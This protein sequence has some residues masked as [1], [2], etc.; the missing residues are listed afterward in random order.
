MA[1]PMPVDVIRRYLAA[2][3]PQVF[4]SGRRRSVIVAE[5]FGEDGA[6]YAHTT[7]TYAMPGNSRD[8]VGRR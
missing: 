6:V 5:A 2:E 4:K 3:F 1:E 8:P 7:M